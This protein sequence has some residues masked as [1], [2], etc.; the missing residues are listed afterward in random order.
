MI[1]INFIFSLIQNFPSFPKNND[2]LCLNR[3]RFHTEFNRKGDGINFY[4]FRHPG[5]Y[6]IGEKNV[7]LQTFVSLQPCDKKSDRFICISVAFSSGF[8]F[9]YSYCQHHLWHGI[10]TICKW[11]KYQY[12]QSSG[13]LKCLLRTRFI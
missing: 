6:T 1:F 13:Q 3:T 4:I 2:S 8:Q 7:L 5:I 12:R 11:L 9:R 10:Q